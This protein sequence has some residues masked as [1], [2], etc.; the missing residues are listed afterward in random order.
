MCGAIGGDHAT[1]TVTPWHRRRKIR[2]LDG[3]SGVQ[4]IFGRISLACLPYGLL[5]EVC[6]HLG[7]R[8]SL[9]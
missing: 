1:H 6:V 3:R 7:P 8:A 5:T 4:S 2:S 9:T